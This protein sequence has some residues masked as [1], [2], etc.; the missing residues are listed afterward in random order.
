MW[1]RLLDNL[2]IAVRADGRTDGQTHEE[3]SVDFSNSAKAPK[4]NEHSFI[5]PNNGRVNN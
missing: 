1:C 5:R 3:A 2:N 4:F